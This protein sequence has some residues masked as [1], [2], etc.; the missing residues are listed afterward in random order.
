MSPK[1]RH[2]TSMKQQPPAYESQQSQ[3]PMQ[4]TATID[5]GYYALPSD[6]SSVRQPKEY[7]DGT[8][9]RYQHNPLSVHEWNETTFIHPT[10]PS[11]D[12]SA[13]PTNHFLPRPSMQTMMHQQQRYHPYGPS[14]LTDPSP[15][16]NTHLS[17]R[18]DNW[19]STNANTLSHP[20]G[21]D[22][23]GAQESHDRQS[24]SVVNR[25]PAYDPVNGQRY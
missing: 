6:D 9:E 20:G 8:A 10:N 21:F 1:N 12:S 4:W 14:T 15:G 25:M 23:E 13:M 19:Y 16:F 22:S 18:H 7:A 11:T 5:Q 24:D 3:S 17:G 2:R